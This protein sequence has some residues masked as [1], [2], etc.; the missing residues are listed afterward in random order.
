M[1]KPCEVFRMRLPSGVTG[2]RLALTSRMPALPVSL[3]EDVSGLA[4]RGKSWNSGTWQHLLR[5]LKALLS[6]GMETSS[7]ATGTGLV[8]SFTRCVTKS[9]LSSESGFTLKPTGRLSGNSSLEWERNYQ[10]VKKKIKCRETEWWQVLARF[11]GSRPTKWRCQAC[12]IFPLFCT[13]FHLVFPIWNDSFLGKESSSCN[14]FYIKLFCLVN[15]KSTTRWMIRYI[16]TPRLPIA[17][18]QD[19][20]SS[21]SHNETTVQ[22]QRFLKFTLRINGRLCP[23]PVCTVTCSR[24]GGGSEHVPVEL[25]II[26]C[27][28]C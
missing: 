3:K 23:F 7:A 4:F 2:Q 14:L 25:F 26:K 22:G 8:G 9:K 28:E 17:E 20:S 1:L 16:A 27:L 13:S 10:M 24:G 21:N 6:P 11:L 18:I 15:P 12:L 5:L 19:T